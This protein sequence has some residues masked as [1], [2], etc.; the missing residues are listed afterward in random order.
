MDANAKNTLRLNNWILSCFEKTGSVHSRIEASQIFKVLARIQRCA[1]DQIYSNAAFSGAVQELPK[2]MDDLAQNM[3]DLTKQVGGLP[4]NMQQSEIKHSRT[5][6]STIQNEV[7]TNAETLTNSFKTETGNFQN[8]V[9]Q[10]TDQA[11]KKLTES[12]AASVRQI[13]YGVPTEKWPTLNVGQ[14]MAA[15][16]LVKK[17]Q[18]KAED[19][20]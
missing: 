17:K 20:E 14:K 8:A 4:T 1:V 18:W 9:K 2:H 12:A 15:K 7:K 16:D 11:F 5:L 13:Q 6:I 19:A 3:K 10:Q